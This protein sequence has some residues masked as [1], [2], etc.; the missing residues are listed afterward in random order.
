VNKNLEKSQYPRKLAVRVL[1]RVLSDHEPLD[2]VL[3]SVSGEVSPS[4]FGWLQ[5]NCAGTLRWKG[6]LDA[7]LDS[8]SIKKKPSG[9]LRK[10]LLLAA[11]QLVAQ[12]RTSVGAVV[13]ETVSEVKAKEGEAPAKF[14]N[15]LLR[16]VADH[17]AQWR[18]QAFRSE[19]DTHS[20]AQWASFP[21]WL[22]EKIV[23]Q[24]GI[25]WAVAY[26]QAS[27]N[28][29]T[30]WI[31]SKSE[32]WH[33]TWAKKGPVPRSWEIEEG[34]LITERPG[35]KEGDF[36]VQDI[37]SQFLVSKVSETLQASFGNRRITALDLCAAPGGKSVGLAWS[38]FEVTATDRIAK[39]VP[40]LQ[41]T[42][43][44]VA[45]NVQIV[46]WE[47]WPACEMQDL[48]WVDAPC[49]GTGILRRHPDV[50]WLR[51]E[52]ELSGLMEV[53]REILQK[54]WE[55]VKPGGYLMYSVC[56]ILQEEGLGA[57]K[58][59]KLESNI[60]NQWLLSPNEAPFGDGFWAVLLRK[61]E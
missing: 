19:M 42:L 15:A 25:E 3:A 47:S 41:Q 12:D 39:R 8:I 36:F 51:Q 11:Y 26:A 34:G 4:T 14:A 35:F 55:L 49:S 27:L 17:A 23:K 32:D 43:S 50:R 7:I 31:S 59:T 33:P 13:S 40:L 18:A 53:Q 54:G 24:R 61:E 1:T 10:V 29:P 28:R 52:K 37:S 2:E 44:R 46:S 22:W 6:R 30:L 48:I 58:D 21:D 60:K 45:P 57:V 56:S 38:G 20:A 9:W 16:K 5:E